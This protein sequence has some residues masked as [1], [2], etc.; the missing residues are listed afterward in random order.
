MLEAA[1]PDADAAMPP[2]QDDPQGSAVMTSEAIEVLAPEINKEEQE[3]EEDAI[4]EA[5]EQ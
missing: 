3:A 1:T 2:A 4:E 5:Q